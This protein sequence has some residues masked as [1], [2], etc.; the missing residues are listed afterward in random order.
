MDWG[1]R[2]ETIEPIPPSLT[3][4]G[5]RAH[6]LIFEA[7]ERMEAEIL[8]EEKTPCP[9]L[10]L[11]SDY[12]INLET[13]PCQSPQLQAIADIRQNNT[14]SCWLAQ[15]SETPFRMTLYLKLH[16][17]PTHPNDCHLQVELF[18]E[19]WQL[20]KDLPFPWRVRIDPLRLFMM[21]EGPLT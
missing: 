4:V 17:P 18:K 5:I 14:F 12:D 15:T 2:L 19:N 6:H 9:L 3:H 11:R 13:I 16:E 20:L 21:G 7:I 1:C 10:S 8:R